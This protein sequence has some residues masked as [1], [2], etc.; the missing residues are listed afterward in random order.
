MFTLLYCTMRLCDY[1]VYTEVC[2]ESQKI[3]GLL[4]NTETVG[5]LKRNYCIFSCRIVLP[6]NM[7]C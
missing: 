3:V 6:C 1:L 7:K 4:K 5:T 2:L